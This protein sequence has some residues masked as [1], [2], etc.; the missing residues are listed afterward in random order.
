[1]DIKVDWKRYYEKNL[2]GMEKQLK[3]A[4]KNGEDWK[5]SELMKDIDKHKEK[6]K[7][8][9]DDEKRGV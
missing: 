9:Y 2:K 8:L 6:Y 3:E 1:M 7:S 4:I 5:I